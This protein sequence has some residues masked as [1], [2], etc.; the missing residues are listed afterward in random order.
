MRYFEQL[1]KNCKKIFSTYF[2]FVQAAAWVFC[3]EKILGVPKDINTLFS[4]TVGARDLENKDNKVML[5]C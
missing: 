5:L 3:G 4:T 1:C 2:C